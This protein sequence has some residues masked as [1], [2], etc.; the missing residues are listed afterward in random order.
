MPLTVYLINRPRDAFAKLHQQ[1]NKWVL[2]ILDCGI[3]K[4]EGV[5]TSHMKAEPAI[6]MMLV[7]LSKIGPKVVMY[8]S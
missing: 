5:R 7:S 1:S 6:Y 3:F 8:V 4:G 2:R